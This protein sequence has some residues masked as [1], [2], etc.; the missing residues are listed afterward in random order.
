MSE[1]TP[2]PTSE[3]DGNIFKGFAFALV[4][5]VVFVAIAALLV[6]CFSLNI[7][8]AFAIAFVI[9]IVLC[10]IGTQFLR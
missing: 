2:T 9:L 5:N 8:W 10:L 4:F 1:N 7:F 3:S 6:M